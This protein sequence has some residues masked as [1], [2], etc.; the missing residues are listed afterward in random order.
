M[1]TIQM[2]YEHQASEASTLRGIGDGTLDQRRRSR[3]VGPA[4][5]MYV[6]EDMPRKV[7]NARLTAKWRRRYG[8]RR[9]RGH[10][11]AS[12]RPR[13][14]HDHRGRPAARAPDDDRPPRVE[15]RGCAASLV[16]YG[17]AP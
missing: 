10:A 8:P 14:R 9:Q 12:A 2:E 5:A 6:P 3:F 1:R 15:P 7:A 11:P 4:V 16:A 17:V 13:K